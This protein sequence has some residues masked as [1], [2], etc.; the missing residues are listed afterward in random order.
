MFPWSGVVPP[1]TALA[2]SSAAQ[3]GRHPQAGRRPHDGCAP[4]PPT[5]KDLI[6]VTPAA[7]ISRFDGNT[8]DGTTRLDGMAYLY[9][10]ER[11]PVQ[12]DPR[13]AD[14]ITQTRV[15]WK[16]MRAAA[17]PGPRIPLEVRVTGTEAQ[18][19]SVLVNFSPGDTGARAPA[20]SVPDHGGLAWTG[21]SLTVMLAA[22]TIVTLLGLLLLGAARRRKAHGEEA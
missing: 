6:A 2:S 15:E 12:V 17:L 7:V 14:R 8:L 4:E 21:T 5:G 18:M 9:P 19:G 16:P 20:P 11:M 3:A 10:G 22:L 13:R 1:R